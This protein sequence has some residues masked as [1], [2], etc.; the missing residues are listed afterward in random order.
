M[1]SSC[2]PPPRRLGRNFAGL[3]K[4]NTSRR[5]TCSV[6]ICPVADSTDGGADEP[7]SGP[8]AKKPKLHPHSGR[9]QNHVAAVETF[10][11]PLKSFSFFIPPKLPASIIDSSSALQEFVELTCINNLKL[12]HLNKEVQTL[13]TRLPLAYQKKLGANTNFFKKFLSSIFHEIQYVQSIK[14][15][16]APKIIAPSEIHLGSI[17]EVFKDQKI[18]H[19][20]LPLE[21]KRVTNELKSTIDSIK[22]I[23]ISE[24]TFVADTGEMKK[25]CKKLAD[26]LQGSCTVSCRSKTPREPGPEYLVEEETEDEEEGDIVKPLSLAR[27]INAYNSSEPTKEKPA[28]FPGD[29]KKVLELI[30]CFIT[31]SIVNFRCGT[32]FESNQS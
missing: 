18:N 1:D 6:D 5:K 4:I 2:F 10:D 26:S 27:S 24:L 12:F 29:N 13:D 14:T 21:L 16:Y 25:L 3:P 30:Q 28:G 31:K 20:Y 9:R 8:P 7:D 15:F 19:L 17:L 11:K 23:D 22:S 32:F